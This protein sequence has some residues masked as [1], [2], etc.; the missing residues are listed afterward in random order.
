M[1]G[2]IEEWEHVISAAAELQNL[3]PGCILVGGSASAI[4]A[5]HRLSM[6]AGHVLTD[7][8]ER[9][10]NLLEFLE[11]HKEWKTARIQPP[12][13]ILGNFLGVET[14]LRQLIRSQ[15]L[16]TE[17]VEFSGR[18]LTIP[19]KAE[20][21]RIKAW[22]I[23]IRNANRDYIDFAAIS[24]VFGDEKVVGALANFDLY[25]QDIYRGCEVSPLNQLARQLAEP[26][27]YDLDGIDIADYKGIVSPLDCW[28]NI[29]KIC[30]R[31]SAILCGEI[32]GQQRR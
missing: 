28:E 8:A 32:A 14:G 11:T 7:L 6:D 12:K 15:P 26:R 20:M 30:N 19:T 1:T 17:T 27:P 29:V 21:L 5:K 9:F 22:L 4:H 13:L 18:I 2:K 31:I 10:E 25:Y 3:V 23:V 16:E 24:R